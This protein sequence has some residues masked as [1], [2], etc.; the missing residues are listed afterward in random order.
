MKKVTRDVLI[1][2]ANKLMFEL[3]E[4]EIEELLAVFDS[5]CQQMELIGEIDVVDSVEPMTFPFEVTNS[6]LREDVAEE[7]L[8]RDDALKNAS[9][10]TD[11]QVRL[12]K[13]VE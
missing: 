10:V 9:D 4:S 11:G 3:S 1:E 8:D 13:V 6:W 12:P 2:T 5:I 7:P